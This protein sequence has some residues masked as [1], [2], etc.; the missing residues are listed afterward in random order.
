[1]LPMRPTY[2]LEMLVNVLII[3]SVGGL[4]SLHGPFWAALLLGI[5]DTGFKYF[6][7]EFG[8]F[9]IYAATLLLLLWRPKGLFGKR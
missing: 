6:F 9:F 8:G 5:S 7:P 3:V 2:A 4:G 1:V